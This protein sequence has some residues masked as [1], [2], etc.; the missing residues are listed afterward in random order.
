MSSISGPRFFSFWYTLDVPSTPSAV[1]AF[2]I[3]GTCMLTVTSYSHGTVYIYAASNGQFYNVQ[4]ISILHAVATKDL[5]L[6]GEHYLVVAVNDNP[7]S[8]VYKWNGM[9]FTASG[10]IDATYATGVDAIMSTEHGSFLALKTLSITAR[11]TIATFTSIYKIVP[12]VGKLVRVTLHQKLEGTAGTSKMHF[13]TTDSKLY[14]SIARS[15]DDCPS[16]SQSLVYEYVNN[17]FV[18]FQ[19]FP[20]G[21]DLYPFT[22]GCNLF[23]VAAG[24]QEG[25]YNGTSVIYRYD[26]F[27]RLFEKFQ[28][29]DD[30][31]A[32]TVEHLVIHHEHFLLLSGYVSAISSNVTGRLYRMDGTSVSMFQQIDFTSDVKLHPFFKL[33]DEY[34]LIAASS[35][36]LALHRWNSLTDSCNAMPKNILN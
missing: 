10:S 19:S 33:E 22:S 26:K 20:K 28:V 16:G 4:N 24:V 8:R 3:E 27:K 2:Y 5:I 25:A 23:L 35:D 9:N 6:H 30:P 29:I 18:L 12:S 34:V 1:H 7:Y 21:Q 17:Q 14:L 32:S 13:F 36:D 31:N 11:N 15:C